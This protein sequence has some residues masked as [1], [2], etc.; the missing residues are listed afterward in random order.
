MAVAPFDVLVTLTAFSLVG[1]LVVVLAYVRYPELR[2]STVNQLVVYLS[3]A[4]IGF[5]VAVLLGGWMVASPS[6]CTVQG[7]LLQWAAMCSSLWTASLGWYV[8]HR[9]LLSKPEE[10]FQRVLYHFGMAAF[11]GSWVIS[12]LVL[13]VPDV[14]G[15]IE[16]HSWCWIRPDFAEIR[17][18]VLL[19]PESVFTLFTLVCVVA[20]HIKLARLTGDSSS[21]ALSHGDR[22]LTYC[23]TLSVL[24][25]IQLANRA[26][27]WLD[28]FHT[29]MWLRWA[30]TVCVPLK[31]GLFNSLMFTTARVVVDGTM[32]KFLAIPGAT[33]QLL[34]FLKREYS[35]EN[36]EFLMVAAAY[37]TG[38]APAAFAALDVESLGWPGGAPRP[39][40]VSK[41]S[42]DVRPTWASS[43]AGGRRGDVVSGSGRRARRASATR[44]REDS[45]SRDQSGGVEMTAQGASASEP[46]RSSPSPPPAS[47]RGQ[48]ASA[49]ARKQGGR[50]SMPP[51]TSA[52]EIA[53]TV[54]ARD[55]GPGRAS[56]PSTRSTTSSRGSSA[57][58][59]HSADPA[60]AAWIVQ[61]YI[62]A[63]A[64]REVNIPATMRRS[65]MMAA[66]TDPSATTFVD[67]EIEVFNLIEHDSF[68]RFVASD[69]FATFRRE[70]EASA[71]LPK[72]RMVGADLIQTTRWWLHSKLLAS[73]LYCRG[74]TPTSRGSALSSAVR[75]GRASFGSSA[76][77]LAAAAAAA[78]LSIVSLDFR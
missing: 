52:S 21:V 32:S 43:E 29:V 11:M 70:T 58:G 18:G 6:L 38:E 56:V 73:V 34:A 53:V 47:D 63:G 17:F 28:P 72:G 15:P 13:V 4:D 69:R 24:V 67:A 78:D 54:T 9:Y 50:S 16:D 45:L 62:K 5:C 60:V 66:A 19:A 23:L 30:N 25:T 36:L 65:V 71:V 7:V 26:L 48:S 51:S 12:V 55:I 20:A 14:Y 10:A 31:Y 37:R 46:P 22:A 77:E 68:R 59:S 42:S 35:D 2:G 41:G 76:D 64:E 27:E 57:S 3:V 75:A 61:R 49:L 8:L 1:A 74:H 44:K 40:L 39:G 33:R